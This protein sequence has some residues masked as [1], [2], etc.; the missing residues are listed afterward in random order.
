[1]AVNPQVYDWWE[2]VKTRHGFP[3]DLVISALQ[4]EMRRGNTEN[5]AMLAYE[6]MTSSAEMEEKLW[7]RL[8]VICVEDTGFGD[9]SA[10]IL[11]NNLYHMHHRFTREEGDRYVFAIHAVRYLCTR[12]KDRSS[13]EMLNWIRRQV[14]TKGAV[15][16]IPDYA[17]D[18]HTGEGKR[19][20]KGLRYFYDVGSRIDPE[21]PDRDR[22]YRERMLALLDEAGE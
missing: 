17:Y 21:L 3:A 6:M 7:S 8:T 11:I 2:Q 14:E 12:Q 10:P 18:M 5:A 9:V 15:P 16:T 1:M 20:G 13:D 22:T 19:M 4:K